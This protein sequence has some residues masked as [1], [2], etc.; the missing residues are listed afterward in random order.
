M[1]KLSVDKG[2]VL[3][4]EGMENEEEEVEGNDFEEEWLYI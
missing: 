4:E 2:G 3:S 1:Q